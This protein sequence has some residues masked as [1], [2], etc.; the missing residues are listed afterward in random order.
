MTRF[1]LGSG[2]DGVFAVVLAEAEGRPR[3][4]CFVVCGMNEPIRGPAVREPSG[5]VCT[6]DFCVPAWG[7]SR[8]SSSR[9]QRPLRQDQGGHW[10]GRFKITAERTTDR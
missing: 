6:R 4:F 8:G 2:G 9:S 5:G 10:S 3:G 1:Q 7:P